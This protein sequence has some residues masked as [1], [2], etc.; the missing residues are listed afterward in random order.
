ML[1]GEA[2]VDETARRHYDRCWQVHS[3]EA[4]RGGNA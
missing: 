1:R 4:R 3:D 2:A